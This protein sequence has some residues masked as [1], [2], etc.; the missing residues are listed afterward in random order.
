MNQ[1]SDIEII[2]E[3]F[4]FFQK[5]QSLERSC[6]TFLEFDRDASLYSIWET[7]TNRNSEE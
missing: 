1:D 5:T 4:Q 7:A 3:H 2:L 6:D